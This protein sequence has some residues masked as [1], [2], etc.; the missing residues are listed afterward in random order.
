MKRLTVFSLVAVVALSGAAA[1]K[2]ATSGFVPLQGPSE[3]FKPLYDSVGG[4]DTARMV[5]TTNVFTAAY[6]RDFVVDG[7]LTKKVWKSAG[8]VGP[9]LPIKGRDFSH[10]TVLKLLYSSSALYIGLEFFQPMNVLR[11][12]YDQD[13]QPI[14]DDDNLEA[15]FLV[16]NKKG[17][18]MLHLAINSLG[19]CW[20]ALNGRAAWNVK[21][22]E[23]RARR[24]DDRWTMEVKLP[25]SGLGIDRP[26]PGDFIGARFC[27]VV[28]SPKFC[29]TSS[30]QLKENGNNAR[31]DFGKLVFGEPVDAA[32][33]KEARS[34]R[35]KV[36]KE[37]VQQRMGEASKILVVQEAMTAAFPDRVHPAYGDAVQAICQMREGMEKFSKGLLSTNEFFALDAG[38]RKYI[39][40]HAYL[41]W[42][43]SPWD[44]GDPGRLPPA[45]AAG[46]PK[47][48]FEQAGNEREAVCLEFTG[49]MCGPRLDLRLVP[50][51][52]DEPKKKRFVSCDAFEIYEEPFVLFEKD[53]ITAPLAP[54]AGNVIT[55]TPGCVTRVWVVFNSKGVRPGDYATRIVLKPMYD[56]NIAE[57]SLD[58]SVKVWN[59]ELPKT[60]D[61]PLKTFF[62]G[63]GYYDNDEV[64]ALKLTHDYHITHGW[65]KSQLYTFGIN[66][67]RRMA[68]RAGKDDPVFFDRRLAETANEEFFRTAKAL[69]MRFVFGWGAP[70]RTPEWFKVM[71]R[72]LSAMGF[73]RSDYIFKT[74]L[75]DEFLKHHIPQN[76]ARREAV[77]R[78]FG[79]NLWF[80]CVYLSTPPPMGATM[81]DIEEAKLP[82][83]YKMFTVID[84]MLRDPKRGP[85]IV[86]RLRRKGC[87][88]WSYKCARYMQ[89]QDVL[90][91]Y[92]FYV[93]ECY[94][95]GFDGAALWISFTKQGDDGWDSR[96][97]YD[98]GALWCGVGKSVLSTKRFEAWREGLEDVAYMDILARKMAAAKTEGK[99][100]SFAQALL[101]ERKNILKTKNQT[102]V[103]EWRLA[104]G[105]AIDRLMR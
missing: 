64:Q 44:K 5:D 58:V 33:A 4:S 78:E 93:W 57:Q 96:D 12:Q 17:E 69:G 11:A 81:D 67:D 71:D 63:P 94:M 29:R 62:W 2:S 41:V 84:G 48:K 22:I 3:I 100:V 25:F 104:V 43:A 14:H 30:P 99:D 59:F 36:A 105:R 70:D 80:Q 46:L 85:D 42:R 61:W 50:L 88:V 34:W 20:D 87:E 38:F 18:D 74:L 54:K 21:G 24:L 73:D 65:T 10:R 102:G 28:H 90:D 72:R 37:R 89:T 92:R 45:K 32:V 8:A 26:V 77:V 40:N 15:F 53:R 66:R 91:Y 60:R 51:T 82:E 86:R 75:K 103:D 47:L 52:V 19:S 95:S 23:C 83:F 27:R 1:Q 79:T 68:R 9:F 35:D 6:V 76:A 101:D 49:L 97:G 16:P 55:L 56:V 7:D 13:D 98:D 31:R 39:G